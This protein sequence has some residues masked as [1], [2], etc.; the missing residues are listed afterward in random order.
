L[1][2]GHWSHL[3]VPPADGRAYYDIIIGG[4]KLELM[5]PSATLTSIRKSKWTTVRDAATSTAR[6]YL[7]PW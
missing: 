7:R 2:R 6:I 1:S 5:L 3:A 4:P